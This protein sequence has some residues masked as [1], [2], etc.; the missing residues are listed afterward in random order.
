[1]FFRPAEYLLVAVVT[2]SLCVSAPARTAQ[3]SAP[4]TTAGTT[5][6]TA[7]QPVHIL[8]LYQQQLETRPMLEF[9]DELRQTVRTQIKGPL[10][11]YQ[12][13]LDF[14]RFA[15]REG[16]ASLTGYFGDKYDQLD[17]DVIVA[18]GSRALSF[19]VERLRGVL[20]NIPIVFALTAAPQT[21]PKLLPSGV[22]GRLASASRFE[23]TLSLARRLQP[24]AERIV[25]IG[26]AGPADSASVA[27]AV[28]AATA[29]HD[30]L[31]IVVLQGLTLDTLLRRV[32]VI[33]RR[34]IVLFVSYRQ[35]GRGQAFEPQD[36]VGSIAHATSAPMY[37]Q[38]R[39]YVGE[40]VVG[41]AV[42]R[43]DDEGFL[44][45]QLVARVLRR[46]PGAPLPP[47][48][49]IT[50]TFVM[51]WRQLRHWSLAENR[52]PPGTD[53]LFREPTLWQR[54]R[55]PV[56]LA[57]ALVCAESVLLGLLLIERRRRKRAQQLAED[58]QRSTEEARRQIAHMGRLAVIGELAATISHELRQPL[59]AI[60]ANAETGAKLTARGG[61][62]MDFDERSL[63]GEIFT[64]IIFDDQL[65][66]DIITRVRALARNENLPQRSVDLNEVCLTAARLL[67]A[68]AV[69]RHAELALSLDPTMPEIV[70]DATQLQQVVLNLA[71]NALDVSAKANK[72]RV[73]ITTVSRDDEVEIAVHDSGPGIPADVQQHLFQS[74]FTTKPTGLGLGLA[75][76]R[77][78]VE[79]HQGK[80]RADNSDG[81]GAT[82]RVVIPRSIRIRA[83]DADY[84][85]LNASTLTDAAAS[86]A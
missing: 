6:R 51:D 82:F 61:G 62:R 60:R 42:T 75:I 74:F 52:L 83:A 15:E 2:A 16:S 35:D 44:T 84:P 69:A 68:E 36:I 26:G 72:P 86:H 4:H 31:P 39:S 17:I 9:G 54:Y 29:R 55:M 27:V 8:V 76:V 56:L 37:T 34:S 59:A 43:F 33:P 85:G 38:L 48:E 25:I 58:R 57:V 12:E 64:D 32:H 13:S 3:D 66:S 47:I 40:G 28:K 1:V 49:S 11:F 50:N 46:P 22:T 7:Q 77:S 21:D 30:S 81:G 19:A 10:E 5:S 79:R 20:P 71:L 23:P 45:G 53:V 41:G 73:T 80:V 14:D 65:A 24:D 78:I 67:H 63:Y 18:V 70:G